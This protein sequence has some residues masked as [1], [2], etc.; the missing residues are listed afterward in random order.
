M[1]TKQLIANL[2]MTGSETFTA[3]EQPGGATQADRTLKITGGDITTTIDATTTPKIE[4]SPIVR[5]VTISG[6]TTIDLTAA[7]GAVLPAAATRSI[8]ASTKKLIAFRLSCPTTNQAAVNVAPGASDPYAIFGA[9]NDIDVRPGW[10]I[11]S[12]LVGANPSHAAVSGTAK[13]IDITGTTGDK[14]TIELYFGS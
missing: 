7:A 5:T 13:N 10:T 14:I 6:T 2:S 11:A 3:A 4:V 8:D 9:G 1:S 12:V